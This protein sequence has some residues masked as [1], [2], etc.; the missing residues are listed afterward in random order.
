MVVSLLSPIEA[1]AVRKA[2]FRLVPFLAV[3]YFVSFLDR[4]NI[5]FAAL[6]MNADIGL[7][8]TAFG[9]GAGIFFA[10]YLLFTVPANL[11][12]Q[13][14]GAGR[15][16][17]LIMVVWGLLSACMAFVTTPMQFYILR[18]LLGAA[19]SGFLPGVILYLTYWFPN[20]VR[21]RI[22][23]NFFAAVPI[24]NV[25]GAPLSTWL[26]GKSVLGLKGW[27]TMFVVE[28][29]P[30]VLLGVI[31]WFY[32]TD[33]PGKATWLSAEEREAL[34]T[35]VSR[36]QTQTG[37]VS[38]R[39]GLVNPLV[40]RFGLIYFFIVVG[41]YGFGFWAP[42]ILK[43][44]ADLSNEAV[45]WLIA[46]PY[47]VA[48]A[49]MYVWGRHSDRTGERVWHVA[50]PAFLGAGGFL[51]AGYAGSIEIAIFAFVLGAVGIYAACPIF[52]T[53]PA[54]ALTGTAA[55]GGIALVN[56]IGNIAG[57]VGPFLMGG[58][59]ESTGSYQVGLWVL[60]ASMVAAGLLVLT[61]RGSKKGKPAT[62]ELD[63]L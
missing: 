42:Q 57:Y 11:M 36:G 7:S 14:L 25:I 38:L 22:I 61:L 27:Q 21:G 12:L 9:L 10:G 24:S 18:F 39:D 44:L 32:L 31:T 2:A 41:L 1:T 37:P 15:W 47:A 28:G 55:A 19:E 40:W 62:P 60:A 33:G 35:A 48:A 4:V 53:L 52:W 20:E 29:L 50:L 30:A 56:S 8:A 13:R 6:T 49:S 43:S 63:L 45:G 54:A 59:R 26:L 51:L 5:G 34:V 46:I 23:G 58:L 3:L 16:M 17:A